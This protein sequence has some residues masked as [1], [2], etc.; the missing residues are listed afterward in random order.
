MAQDDLRHVIEGPAEAHAIY[1]KPDTL[2]DRLIN[3]V[4]QTLFEAFR[5]AGRQITQRV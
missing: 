1:F 3:E 2:V 5:L 4:V